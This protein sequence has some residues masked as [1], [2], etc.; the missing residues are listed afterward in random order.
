M[1]ETLTKEQLDK[2]K[3]EKLA[4]IRRAFK[5][6]D[7]A[8]GKANSAYLL[9]DKSFEQ[10]PSFSTGSLMLDI[11]T[12]I[13]GIGLGRV[14]ESYGKPSSG[15]TM[16]MLKSIANAQKAGYICAF[17]DQEQTFDPTWA[18]KLGVQL[19]ELILSQPDSMEEAFRVIDGL[20]DSEVVS[21]I[22]LDSVAAL[23]PEAELED[24]ISK[25]NIALIARGM[26]KFL[27]RITPKCARNNCTVAF[28]NQTRDN[29]GIMYGNP[30]TTGG[31]QALKFYS[32]M[33]FE[34]STV[35]G[36]TVK[37]KLGTQDV[38]IGHRVR[39]KIVKNKM[40]PPFRT[41]EFMV[42]YDGRN[43]DPSDEIADIVVSQGLIPKYNAKGE[44]DPKGRTYKYSFEDEELK[45]SK[46]DD[47][48]EALKQCPKIQQHF[49]DMIKNGDIAP[50]QLS[51]KENIDNDDEEKDSMFDE[52]AEEIVSQEW[53]GI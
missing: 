48:K 13:G 23:V 30:V 19:D 9:Q 6:I 52:G 45:V 24:D 53:D 8:N 42:Y 27:R 7:K 39:V 14:I 1:K 21:F 18:Q 32:S 5:L 25:Q 28:I 38:P 20:I 29:V 26:S 47:I 37:E 17:I 34:V 31:G 51:E 33:R 35:S 16:L 4:T 22:V 10:P 46:M 3:R 12:G 49:I 44:I 43:M 2:I 36:S 50:A 11:A 41:A 40:A 15:K